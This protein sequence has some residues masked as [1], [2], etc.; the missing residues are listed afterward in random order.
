VCGGGVTDFATELVL[1]VDFF[2]SVAFVTGKRVASS[3][4]CINVCFVLYEVQVVAWRV[5]V[6]Q[7]SFLQSVKEFRILCSLEFRLEFQFHG[8][9]V[10][11][12]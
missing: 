4:H 6:R 3:D 1:F 10:Y 5:S 12:V 8:K 11:L 2:V 9:E 7:V